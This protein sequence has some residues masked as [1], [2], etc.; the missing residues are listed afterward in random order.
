MDIK[1][2]ED[3]M[4]KVLIVDD[5]PIMR[6]HLRAI[7]TE[8]GH[9]IV[10]EAANGAQAFF[11]YQKHLPDLVTLDITMPYM[12]GVD[13]LK[14][15]MGEYPNARVVIVSCANNNKII[16][17]AI[18]CGAENYVLKPFTVEK[19]IGVINQVLRVN[20]QVNKETIEKIYRTLNSQI[21]VV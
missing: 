15:I 10:A 16:L 19:V 13:A 17:E 4:A 12:N 2:Q 5:A 7:L 11:E 3:K 1:C 14:K 9:T 6:R 18:Q 21:L 8:I 20:E